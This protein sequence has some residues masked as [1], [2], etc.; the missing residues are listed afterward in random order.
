MIHNISKLNKLPYRIPLTI[1]TSTKV[2]TTLNTNAD[3]TKLIPLVP[4]SIQ[5]LKYI[6]N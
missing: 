5:L 1:S 3:K 6:S 2:G 4:L